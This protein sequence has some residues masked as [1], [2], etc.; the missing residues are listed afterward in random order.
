MAALVMCPCVEWLQNQKMGCHKH[1]LSLQS[2]PHHRWHSVFGACLL[3]AS[4]G[5]WLS[6][7]SLKPMVKAC[8]SGCYSLPLR[9]TFR[10]C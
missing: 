8:L 5:H 7:Q 4:L 1:G 2:Y 9:Q 6:R 10:V 3:L